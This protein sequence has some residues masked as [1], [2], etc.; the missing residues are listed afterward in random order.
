MFII[1]T[2]K[3]TTPWPDGETALSKSLGKLVRMHRNQEGRKDGT[4]MIIV[5]SKSARTRTP[6]KQRAATAGRRFL[7]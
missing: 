1:I 5:D 3:W 6:P 2:K 7:E 4:A